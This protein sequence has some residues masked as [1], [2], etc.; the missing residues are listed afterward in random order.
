MDKTAEYV[1]KNSDDFERTVLDRHIG[2]NRFGFL[3]PWDRY[4]PYYQLMKQYSRAQLQ[5]GAAPSEGAELQETTVSKPNL[6]K[7]SSTGSVSFKLQTK[8]NP[9]PLVLAP[10]CSEFNAEESLED[11]EGGDEGRNQES[12]CPPAKKQRVENGRS[13]RGAEEDDDIGRTVQVCIF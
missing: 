6:Q 10:P 7:L 8:S 3:N 12:E 11:M 4:H 2:D 9:S 13:L 1:A 5:Q